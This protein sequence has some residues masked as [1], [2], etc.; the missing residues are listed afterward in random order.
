MFGLVALGAWKIRARSFA[1]LADRAARGLGKTLWWRPFK[2]RFYG[3]TA[4][5]KPRRERAPEPPPASDVT[6]HRHEN[7]LYGN[8]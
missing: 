5:K 6:T 7:A 4:P 1:V 2:I 3:Q 8:A